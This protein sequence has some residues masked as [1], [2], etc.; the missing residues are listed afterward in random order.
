LTEFIAGNTPLPTTGL[1]FGQSVPQPLFL[2]IDLEVR[3][4]N[5]VEETLRFVFLDGMGEWYEKEANRVTLKPLP[6]EILFLLQQLSRPISVIFVAPCVMVDP[7]RGRDD[8][9]RNFS[10]ECLE[11]TMDQ[12]Q[13][14][15][16]NGEYDN[17]LLLYSKWDSLYRPNEREGR[18]YSG[19][20][21]AFYETVKSWP[22]ALAKF[23]TLSHIRHD[24]KSVMPYSAAWMTDDKRILPPG[25]HSPVFNLFNRTL[26]NWL[27]GNAATAARG[28]GFAERPILYED[29]S[30]NGSRQRFGYKSVA[31]AILWLR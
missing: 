6:R 12:Y 17:L 13:T 14:E 23:A 16:T 11:Y 24:G 9:L 28:G 7:Q 25:D 31:K 10:H 4:A 29:V 20:A 27:Y 26:W 3:R 1:T 21:D 15:R 30:P 5:R 19:D 8:E 2:P 18:F 22:Y